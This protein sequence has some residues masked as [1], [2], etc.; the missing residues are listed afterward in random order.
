MLRAEVAIAAGFD[1]SKRK[2][3]SMPAPGKPAF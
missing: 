1:I 2:P 3:F